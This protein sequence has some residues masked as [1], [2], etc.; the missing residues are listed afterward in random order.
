M[1]SNQ[2][3]CQWF[4]KKFRF[5]LNFLC[6]LWIE[7]V[8]I[9][10]K[11]W[12]N[13]LSLSQNYQHFKKIYKNMIT[14]IVEVW[15]TIFWFGW[16]CNFIAYRSFGLCVSIFLDSSKKIPLDLFM[17]FLNILIKGLRFVSFVAWHSECENHLVNHPLKT[18]RGNILKFCISFFRWKRLNTRK[19]NSHNF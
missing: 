4:H 12:L 7:L 18:L 17:R 8:K 15:K 9:R 1:F 13:I 19:R 11:I 14:L 3:F 10:N 16:C 5:S 2:P 6:W